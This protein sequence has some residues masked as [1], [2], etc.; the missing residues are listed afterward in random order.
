MDEKLFAVDS[1]TD[2]DPFTVNAPLKDF[3]DFLETAYIVQGTI[4][5]TL[6]DTPLRKQVDWS[7]L[8]KNK[9]VS[10]VAE[11]VKNEGLTILIYLLLLFIIVYYY[12]M[13]IGKYYFNDI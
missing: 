5:G 12:N 10:S 8:A 4:D 11:I 1:S 3:L 13:Y 6:P 2:E 7:E 9:F